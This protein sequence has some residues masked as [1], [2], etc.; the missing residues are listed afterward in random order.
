MPHPQ[1]SHVAFLL[2]VHPPI[3]S[4]HP[5][6]LSIHLSIYLSI[7]L[8]Y[9]SLP[10][11]LIYPSIHAP[12][13]LSYL[14]IHSSI[15]LLY[16]SILSLSLSLSLSYLLLLAGGQMDKPLWTCSDPY[17]HLHTSCT[18]TGYPLNSGTGAFINQHL[19]AACFFT[20]PG[21]CP[22]TNRLSLVLTVWLQKHAQYMA[23]LFL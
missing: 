9:T 21:L 2:R 3:L 4:I 22:R 7:H 6:Y 12:T 23:L 11:H 10:I 1:P 20:E 14:S 16:P 15:Y 13:H 8:S 17:S 18:P 19:A 5:S